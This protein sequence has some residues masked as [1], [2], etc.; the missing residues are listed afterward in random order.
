MLDKLMAA[1]GAK[2]EKK[3][4]EI[5]EA[6]KA[7]LK[8]LVYDDE[9]VDELAP[10]FAALSQV[11]GFNK[12]FDLLETKERQIEAIAGTDSFSQQT[13]SDIQVQEETT[14]QSTAQPQTDVAAILAQRFKS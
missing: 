4:T 10:I 11:E 14:E 8:G 13:T 12:V 6:L 7:K 5:D 3:V 1:F 2:Q 9:L